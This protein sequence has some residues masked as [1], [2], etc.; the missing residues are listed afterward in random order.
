M[1]KQK[2]GAPIKE[3][4]TEIIKNII[5]NYR[6][7]E[8]PTGRISYLKIWKYAAKLSQAQDNNVECNNALKIDKKYGSEDLW[9]KNNKK[10]GKPNLGK[11]LVDEANQ[12]KNYYIT[13][14]NNHS[15]KIPNVEDAVYKLHSKEDII[16]SL[17]PLEILCI[18]Y[19]R[20]VGALSKQLEKIQQ[21]LEFYKNLSIK[22]EEAIFKLARYG[23]SKDSL[24][25][26]ILNTGTSKNKLVAEALE[27]IFINPMEFLYNDISDNNQ[28]TNT[29][30][31]KERK[32]KLTNKY[33]L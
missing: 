6:Q 5:Y 10:T 2:P 9:R 11:K 14:T 32:Q 3:Y 17:K 18:D 30:D 21:E 7:H 31:L 28:S 15:T 25:K 23:R 26:N 33:G 29:I 1:A 22:Q 8:Q 4:S 24:V 19:S 12:I 20:K 16:E 27:N 13:D